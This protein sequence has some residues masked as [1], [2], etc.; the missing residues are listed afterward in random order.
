MYFIS[1]M[2]KQQDSFNDKEKENTSIMRF[3]NSIKHVITVVDDD[4][5]MAF[6]DL[7]E[8]KDVPIG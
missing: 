8:I 3:V 5:E 6:K 7:P 1:L 2:K 4:I